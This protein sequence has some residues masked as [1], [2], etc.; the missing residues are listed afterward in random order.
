[1]SKLYTIK[2]TT[3]PALPRAAAIQKYQD[4]LLMGRELKVVNTSKPVPEA[5]I[6]TAC[7]CNS[8]RCFKYRGEA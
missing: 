3:L 5:H 1:M 7:E 6:A 2:G 8:V 4:H